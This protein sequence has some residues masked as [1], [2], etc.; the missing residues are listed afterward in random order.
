MSYSTKVSTNN[1]S[2]ASFSTKP[3]YQ[4]PRTIKPRDV[5]RDAE[6]NVVIWNCFCSAIYAA[7]MKRRQELGQESTPPLIQCNGRAWTDFDEYHTAH[8]TKTVIC[9]QDG[10]FSCIPLQSGPINYHL[11]G[12]HATTAAEMTGETDP[13]KIQEALFKLTRLFYNKDKE[14]WVK[15]RPA[16][17]KRE[18]VP[19]QLDPDVPQITCTQ[20]GCNE[21][22]YMRKKD[23]IFHC[24]KKHLPHAASLLGLSATADKA[25]VQEKL[26]EK[27]RMFFN[28]RSGSKGMWQLENPIKKPLDRSTGDAHPPFKIQLKQ[29]FQGKP[30]QESLEETVVS[31]ETFP[32]LCHYSAA[33]KK[34]SV[35]EP[36]IL[37]LATTTEDEPA[38]LSRS[39]SVA[40]EEEPGPLCR[41]ISV[42]CEDEPAP[43]CRSIS[44]SADIPT[45]PSE[46]EPPSAP[47]SIK[48]E[49]KNRPRTAR[50][51]A[52]I[53][54]D[55]SL[56]VIH[57]E[58]L[59]PRPVRSTNEP[60][61][62]EEKIIKR[63]VRSVPDEVVLETSR[64]EKFCSQGPTCSMRSNTAN[65]CR[66]NH[67][68]G[69]EFLSEGIHVPIYYCKWD[70]RWNRNQLG[71]RRRC[72][73]REC[74]YD[75]AE[76]HADFWTKKDKPE[77]SV[78]NDKEMEY[79]RQELAKLQAMF[80]DKRFVNIS[81]SQ[82][83]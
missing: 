79:L 44:M 1:T 52:P 7:D 12:D 83:E 22:L 20:D 10:C 65:P 53:P 21:T 18:Y 73:N 39:I 35:T 27:D 45:S 4:L 82:V 80:L 77:P 19:R 15:D 54:L 76:G 17:E 38:P 36:A 50:A 34:V 48:Q 67:V 28:K 47:P 30:K 78:S 6:G 16:Y 70:Y 31:T 41:S 43:L 66:Q 74:I 3:F 49:R 23:I 81:E 51:I 55:S 68:I 57:E 11:S 60:L 71:K 14:E 58:P 37:Q 25:D 33:C 63:P 13:Q 69:L 56:T 59:V 24:L 61:T 32:P 2:S 75:H 8:G 29:A 5:E 62:L 9:R 46:N 40:C 42:A 72:A 64:L 26:F